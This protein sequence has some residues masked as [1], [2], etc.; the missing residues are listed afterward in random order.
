MM[1]D[2]GIAV[3]RRWRVFEDGRFWK[4]EVLGK[5]EVRDYY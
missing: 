2:H 1:N 4:M 5:M 3:F